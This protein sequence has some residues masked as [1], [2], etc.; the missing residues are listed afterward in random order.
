MAEI[1]PDIDINTIEN[2][3]EK[4]FYQASRELPFG[5]TVLY[6]YKYLQSDEE[7]FTS[8]TR[9]AD[10]IIV[11]PC[12]GYLVVE[13]KQGDI[14]YVNGRW[15]EFKR[16]DYRPLS[17]DPVE[18]ARRTMFAILDEYKKHTGDRFPLSIKY[19]ICFPECNKI[20]GEFPP[21]LDERSVFLFDDLK[22][23]NQKI[24]NLFGDKERK[25][26]IEAVSLLL[27]KILCP[28]FKVFAGLENRIA[29]FHERAER[30]LTEEQ[31]RVLEETELDKRKIFFGA[32]G[33]GKTYIA[34]EK[35][36]R[37]AAQ[38]KRVF[39]TCYNKNLARS[40]FSNLPPGITT[41]NFHN[42]IENMLEENG[43]NLEKEKA[44]V[45]L[46]AYYKKILPEKAFDYYSSVCEDDKFDAIIVDEGQDFKETWITCLEAMLKK[47][48]EFYIFADPNQNLFGSD[49]DKIS[50]I[51][52]SKHRLTRNLRNAEPINEWINNIVPEANLK[53]SIKGGIP[54]KRLEWKTREEERRMIA[55]EIGRL[56]SQGVQLKRIVILS[57]YRKENSCL[58]GVE[59]I[60]EWPLTEDL[61]ARA[62]AV[63]FQT[64]RSFKGL[65]ADIVFLIDVMKDSRVCTDADIYVGGSRA[66]FLLYIFSKKK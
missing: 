36:K 41:S 39:L 44:L 23:L 10:F 12:L 20:T 33:S 40:M 38:G 54:V 11:H 3:G 2:E 59:R 31:E 25:K 35:A 48:G 28:S 53:C 16:G 47:D 45:G 19:A 62:N 50:R 60:K 32:A 9:E 27:N 65:E 22:N 18:Q 43:L 5:Y 56:V 30:I 64:I 29:M 37:I 17:K 42:F 46:D 24:L 63:R 58:A 55:S 66:R 1:I 34:M 21:D 13:V 57:P 8:P 52:V 7:D 14:A 61:V 6:S 51:P 26:E 49:I 15:C 4:A